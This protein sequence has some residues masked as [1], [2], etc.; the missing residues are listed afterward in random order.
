MESGDGA[1]AARGSY[2]TSQRPPALDLHATARNVEVAAL[3]SAAGRE[4]GPDLRGSLQAQLDLRGAGSE[5]ESAVASLNGK[6]HV[7]IADGA[8]V[9]FNVA[10]SVLG[11]LTGVSGLSQ[12]VS[13]RVRERHPEVFVT[14]DT[15]F[16]ALTATF[17]I[18]RRRVTTNDLLLAAPAY[19]VRAVGSAGFDRRVDLDG[20]FLA[21][22]G[23]AADVLAD[24]REARF[25]ANDEGKLEIPF[26][27][28][29]RLPH[30]RLKPDAQFLAATLGKALG[31]GLDRLLQP[32]KKGKKRDGGAEDLL[33]KGLKNLFR[34]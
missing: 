33:E 21:S 18:A 30:P 11:G 31:E 13:P 22:E 6:G 15:R 20:R 9:D 14:G 5:R 23:L 25:L 17:E 29:G 4:G 2:D 10:E 16:D 24:A 19:T 8:I 3:L 27:L 26:R 12:L 32:K 34:E 7:R 1:L 28:E